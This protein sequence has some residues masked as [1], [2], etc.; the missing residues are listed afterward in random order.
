MSG[1]IPSRPLT[2]QKCT[3]EPKPTLEPPTRPDDLWA[4]ITAYFLSQWVLGWF[5]K[6]MN[7]LN[8]VVPFTDIGW[9]RKWKRNGMK[10]KTKLIFFLP[11]STLISPSKLNLDTHFSRKLSQISQAGLEWYLST[12]IMFCMYPIALPHCF[13]IICSFF[14]PTSQL[15]L[16]LCYGT[17]LT[18]LIFACNIQQDPDRF[19]KWIKHLL[20]TWYYETIN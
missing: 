18:I 17:L 19:Y 7:H 10:R 6:W 2:G 16:I 5:F 13:I 14:F 8:M 15:H 4:T 12:T 20:L 11:R 1:E 9:K 3:N